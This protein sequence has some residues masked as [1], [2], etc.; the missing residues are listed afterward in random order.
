MHT[1]HTFI[2]RLMTDTD[3][4]ERLRGALQPLAED[5]VYPFADEY[6]LLGLLRQFIQAN[7][8]S[9]DNTDRGKRPKTYP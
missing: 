4:P 7:P 9:S 1:L 8:R 6:A 5:N 2:L 3:N